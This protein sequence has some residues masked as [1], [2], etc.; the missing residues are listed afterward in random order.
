MVEAAKFYRL[1]LAGRPRDPS[2]RRRLCA[3]LALLGELDEARAL[4]RGL[5]EDDPDVGIERAAAVAQLQPEPLE[6]YVEG[7]RKAGF[8]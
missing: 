5:M 8:S 7:L 1:A 6:R 3:T 2:F 4:A